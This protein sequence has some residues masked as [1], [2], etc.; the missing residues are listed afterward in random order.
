LLI[1]A[2]AVNLALAGEEVGGAG[3]SGPPPNEDMN[4]I[5]TDFRGVSIQF[6]DEREAPLRVR[7]IYEEIKSAGGVPF[8][9]NDY[10]AMGAW[11]DW[12][13]IWWKDCKPVL[14]APQ[15]TTICEKL[16][17][18]ATQA[19][20][21]IPHQLNLAHALLDQYGVNIDERRRMAEV[22]RLFCRLLP[23]LIVNIALA[24]RGLGLLAEQHG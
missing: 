22:N 9:L 18:A 3:S 10:R 2:H 21:L 5:G 20:V 1:I 23:G 8:V 17:S 13:E 4:K 6:V 14:R 7:T 19:A 24:R 11:P 16:E 15:Y 12:L